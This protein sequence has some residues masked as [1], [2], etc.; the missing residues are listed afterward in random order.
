[1]SNQLWPTNSVTRTRLGFPPSTGPNRDFGRPEFASESLFDLH[2]VLL[3]SSFLKSGSLLFNLLWRAVVELAVEPRMP[4]SIAI[5]RTWWPRAVTSRCSASQRHLHRLMRSSRKDTLSAHHL[6]LR[7]LT[8][9]TA[10]KSPGRSDC[11][12][13][14]AGPPDCATGPGGRL[15]WTIKELANIVRRRG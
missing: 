8:H 2:W 10:E 12:M 11:A 9:S 3:P 7:R 5:E 6:H 1:M 4:G 14:T 13:E 15:A